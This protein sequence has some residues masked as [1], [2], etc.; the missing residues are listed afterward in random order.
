M[1]WGWIIPYSAAWLMLSCVPFFQSL[2]DSL[3]THATRISGETPPVIETQVGNALFILF[4]Y[5][6]MIFTLVQ[7]SC[8]LFVCCRLGNIL[9]VIGVVI[10]DHNAASLS[11]RNLSVSIIVPMTSSRSNFYQSKPQSRGHAKRSPP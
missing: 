6:I 1:L 4:I 2:R 8:K 5:N 9:L 10:P 3:L 7:N 11:N